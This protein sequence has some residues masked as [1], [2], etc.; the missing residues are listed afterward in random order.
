M[1]PQETP[2]G[3]NSEHRQKPTHLRFPPSSTEYSGSQAATGKG[4]A[5]YSPSSSSP[6]RPPPPPLGS[7]SLTQQSRYPERQRQRLHCAGSPPEE[8]PGRSDRPARPEE[9]AGVAGAAAG[10]REREGRRGRSSPG[11][12]CPAGGVGGGAPE[13]GGG[14]D[15]SGGKGEGRCPQVKIKGLGR[16]G[17]G[18]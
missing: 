16:M 12:A 2:A 5:L 15:L 3:E 6:P 7:P 10:A 1:Q 18:Q 11:G 9:K 14:A 17:G 4:S 13:R 8:D